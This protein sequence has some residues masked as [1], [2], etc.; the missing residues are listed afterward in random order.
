MFCH[1]IITAVTYT[2]SSYTGMYG[3]P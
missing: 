1:V 3:G 2:D